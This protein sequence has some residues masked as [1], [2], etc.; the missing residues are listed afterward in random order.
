[1]YILP[2][3]TVAFSLCESVVCVYHYGKM[4]GGPGDTF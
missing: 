2:A 1:M 3:E 4:E